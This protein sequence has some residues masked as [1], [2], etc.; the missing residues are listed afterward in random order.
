MYDGPGSA[1]VFV[2]EADAHRVECGPLW[3]ERAPLS[4]NVGGGGNKSL[5]ATQLDEGFLRPASW[6]G[7]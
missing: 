6:M 7:P 5:Y 4:D 1:D 2:F 3:D